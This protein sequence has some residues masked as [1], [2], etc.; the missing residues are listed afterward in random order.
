M[1][2]SDP[3]HNHYDPADDGITDFKL[4]RMIQIKK[5]KVFYLEYD[6]AFKEAELIITDPMRSNQYQTLIRRLKGCYYVRLMQLDDRGDFQSSFMF[7][8]RQCDNYIDRPNGTTISFTETDRTRIEW[9][10]EASEHTVCVRFPNKK[11][12]SIML[13][14]SFD[15]SRSMEIREGS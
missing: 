15:S 6:S 4:Q 14:R 8:G 7:P 9:K 11:R 3:S 10:D 12:E 5:N 13:F 2:K 1:L